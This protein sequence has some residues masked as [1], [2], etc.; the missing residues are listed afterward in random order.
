MAACEA[1][2]PF[3]YV[4]AAL[5]LAAV[6]GGHNQCQRVGKLDGVQASEQIMRF[7][8]AG[9]GCERFNR[10]RLAGA[11]ESRR[12]MSCEGRGI[13]YFAWLMRARGWFERAIE[14]APE[15]VATSDATGSP[16]AS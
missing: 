14:R 12:G 6:W 8:E 9:G 15:D 2:L 5:R 7:R 3:Y 16:P 11:S 10:T 4:G 13:G 1:Q